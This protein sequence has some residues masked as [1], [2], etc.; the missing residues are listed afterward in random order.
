MPI[1]SEY[2][3]RGMP[4]EEIQNERKAQLT[5]I[6]RLRQR[7]VLVIAADL[8]KGAVKA[9]VAILPSDLLSIRDQLDGLSGAAIDVILETPGGSGEAAEDIVKLI[10]AKYDRVGMIVPGTAKS[11]GTIIVMAGDEILMDE[12]SALGP[13]DAQI[14]W[15]GKVFSAHALLQGLVRIKNEVTNTHTLNRAYV[16]ILQNISPGELEDAQNALEFAQ[17]LVRDWLAR[18]KFK[19]W[20]IHSST[21]QR[22]TEEHKRQRAQQIAQELCDH[23]RWKTTAVRSLISQIGVSHWDCRG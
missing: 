21:G 2:L 22:V 23:S 15:Q 1:Y 8:D 16:P 11:A 7:D 17:E 19:D 14:S 18:Y 6:S 4:F 13:I 5:R 3:N 12:A 9:P 10:R 20:D